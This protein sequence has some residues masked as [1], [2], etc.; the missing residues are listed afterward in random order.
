MKRIFMK[1]IAIP[2]VVFGTLLASCKTI[3]TVERAESQAAPQYVNDKRVISDESLN[4]K[5]GVVDVKE[6]KVSGD[7]LKVEVTL[8]NSKNKAKTFLYK[9]EWFN[10]D[11]MTVE[12]VTST[13]LQKEI[14][15]QERL[16]VSAV[17]PNPNVVDFKL[18]LQEPR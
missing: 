8:F 3:N 1:W 10:C 4:R 14:Q 5:V 12:P 16:G 18:K 15:G 9:F 2:I 11:G 13:W 7:L 6:A 17:A